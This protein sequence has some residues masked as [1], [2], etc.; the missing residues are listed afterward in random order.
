MISGI[1]QI[2]TWWLPFALLLAVGF[3]V[4]SG[5]AETGTTPPPSGSELSGTIKINGSNTVTPLSAVWAEE[6]MK[7]H[8]KVSIAVS[9]PGSGAGIAALING[10]TD[11]C[12][13]SREI[14]AREI[15]QAKSNGVDPFETVVAL[16]ALSV[17]AEP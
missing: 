2:R 16:D 9:G 15:E 17:V 1:K 6:F 4:I 11:I 13:A 8:P 14:K 10:T 5:C 12:Q 7:T 3:T